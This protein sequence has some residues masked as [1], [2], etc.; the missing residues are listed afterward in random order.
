MKRKDKPEKT[1]YKNTKDKISWWAIRKK[2]I[3]FFNK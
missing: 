3:K 2:I 1:G